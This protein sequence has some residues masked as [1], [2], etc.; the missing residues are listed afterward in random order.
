[1]KW[2]AIF[3]GLAVLA[4]LV[5]GYFHERPHLQRVRDWI[6]EDQRMTNAIEV[7]KMDQ[8]RYP[9]NLSEIYPRYYTP[10]N[11]TDLDW[12]MILECGSYRLTNE[13][14]ELNMPFQRR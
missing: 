4:W 9:T 8:G 10:S 11:T 3:L 6:S 5:M 2:V 12:K 13:T 1:M 14:Y 7:F